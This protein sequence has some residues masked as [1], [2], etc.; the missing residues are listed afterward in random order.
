MIVTMMRV[1]EMGVRV[2]QRRMSMTVAMLLV[3]RYRFIVRVLVMGVVDVRV[4]VL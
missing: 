4:R 2:G 3:G 1:G